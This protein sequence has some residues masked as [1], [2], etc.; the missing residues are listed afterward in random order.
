MKNRMFLIALMFV[1]LIPSWGVAMEGPA[2]DSCPVNMA[3]NREEH[4]AFVEFNVRLGPLWKHFG[5]DSFQFQLNKIVEGHWPTARVIELT[6]TFM[7]RVLNLIDQQYLKDSIARTIGFDV[8]EWVEFERDMRTVTVFNGILRTKYGL[9]AK[10]VEALTKKIKTAYGSQ[11]LTPGLTKEERQLLKAQAISRVADM[12]VYLQRWDILNRAIID[13]KGAAAGKQ[14]LMSSIGLTAGGLMI[15]SLVYTGPIVAAA[16]A[17]GASLSTDVILAAQL[18]RLGQVA[19]ASGLGAAGTPTA[20]LLTDTA[21]V[22]LRA[23]RDS[24]NRGTV[25]ACEIDQQISEWKKK[26]VSPYVK[27]TVVGGTIGFGGGLLTLTPVGARAILVASTFGVGVAQLYA[28]GKLHE[29]TVLSLAEYQMALEAHKKGDNEKAREHLRKSR[30]YAQ[31]A[32]ERA[33]ETIVVAPLATHVTF[34]FRSALLQGEA[35]IRAV[36]ANSSDTLPMS[37]GIAQ[38]SLE[39][40]TQN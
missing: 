13:Q 9:W 15:A 7:E 2:P 39:S 24:A 20:L 1:S 37:L 3:L 25:Y 18:A 16:G 4:D 40:W 28:A 30:V 19:A 31:Q 35:A 5:K 12:S 38:E 14:L 33:L 26:G 29:N 10:K 8:P 27:A 36:F 23:Q 6:P 11:F 32:G 34:H 21:A 22:L 17:Y